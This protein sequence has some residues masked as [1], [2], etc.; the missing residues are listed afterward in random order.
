MGRKAEGQRS[1]NVKEC[2]T[3]PPP[4]PANAIG[5]TGRIH[6]EIMG[7][8]PIRTISWRRG[9]SAIGCPPPGGSEVCQRTSG[10]L[11]KWVEVLK[12]PG[13]VT[14][15][16]RKSMG[17]NYDF[18]ECI[19][20]VQS[21]FSSTSLPPTFSCGRFLRQRTEELDNPGQQFDPKARERTALAI[22][23]VGQCCQW[24][25][26]C[27]LSYE[28]PQFAGPMMS[29]LQIGAGPSVENVAAARTAVVGDLTLR[30]PAAD[31]KAVFPAATG[32][33]QAFSRTNFSSFR[34]Y[35]FSVALSGLCLFM[36]PPMHSAVRCSFRF[37][38]P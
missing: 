37:K 25:S 3:P 28:K 15:H 10:H 1:A 22:K 31:A 6:R 34:K 7:L 17:E 8:G 20:F 21:D 2:R 13:I 26:F 19:L 16:C 38:S 35:R 29:A 32:A 24:F 14:R 12:P 9:V 5:G 23:G 11:A 4:P 33:A 27:S 36:I 30:V 18:Q